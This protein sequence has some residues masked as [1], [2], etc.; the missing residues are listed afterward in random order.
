MF[1][2]IEVRKVKNGFIVVITDE[3]DSNEYVF[4]T[5]RKALRMIKGLMEMKS[6]DPAI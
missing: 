5:S 6:S 4:D 2:T 3:D 1:E